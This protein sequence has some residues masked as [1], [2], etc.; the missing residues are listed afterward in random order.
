MK[1]SNT[2]ENLTF[3]DENVGETPSQR[4]SA[5]DKLISIDQLFIKFTIRDL[6]ENG[7][8]ILFFDSR[9]R[10]KTT[11]VWTPH[12]EKIIKTKMRTA[13][14]VST[15]E[16][17]DFDNGGEMLIAG[18]GNSVYIRDIRVKKKEKIQIG[19]DIDTRSYE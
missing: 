5:I 17:P 11:M 4:S 12:K 6:A 13:S 15:T 10:V 8:E 9:D 2:T 14:K 1:Q 3:G 19:H 16:V 7:I 18:S